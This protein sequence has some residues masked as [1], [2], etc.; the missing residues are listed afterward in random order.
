MFILPSTNY[1]AISQNKLQYCTINNLEKC[2]EISI[3]DYICQH[4]EPLSSV[5]VKPVCET[6]LLF[7]KS[8]IPKSCDTR[9]SV[10]EGEIWHRLRESN[11]F[12]YILPNPTTITVNCKGQSPVDATLLKTGIISLSTGC[13]AFTSTTILTTFDRTFK[14]E[15][16]SVLPEFDIITDDCC[17]KVKPNESHVHL[18][19]LRSNNLNLEELK[20]ASHKLDHIS[21]LAKNL[22]N[23]ESIYTKII[24]NN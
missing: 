19:P 20:V 21:K 8:S 6:E 18:I 12:I 2:K 7:V 17:N 10:I 24:S 3:K 23:T 1:I 16:I 15:F 11:Q 9:V 4:I 22:K 5:H 14:S 13:K